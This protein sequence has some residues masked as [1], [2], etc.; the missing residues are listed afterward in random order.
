MTQSTDDLVAAL[1][2][3]ASFARNIE[4]SRLLQSAAD[5]L[6]QLSKPVGGSYTAWL[7]EWPEDDNV[8]V[9]WWN[10]AAGWMR[11][12]SKAVHFVRKRDAESFITMSHFVRGV[13]ATEHKFLSA[14]TPAEGVK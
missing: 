2:K 4:A 11:D 8:P 10:P 9:R 14:P 1:E 12:A 5:R 13:V 7:I 3:S 6:A